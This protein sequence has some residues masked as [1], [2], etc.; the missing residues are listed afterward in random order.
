MHRGKNYHRGPSLYVFTQI[1]CVIFNGNNELGKI[2]RV[3]GITFFFVATSSP[4][5]YFVL[6]KSF[7]G[8][9]SVHSSILYSRN[10]EQDS[11]ECIGHLSL[12][13][14]HVVMSVGQEPHALPP[15]PAALLLPSPQRTLAAS[16]RHSM[17][18]DSPRSSVSPPGLPTTVF[19]ISFL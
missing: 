5:L 1:A 4:S 3:R 17:G 7:E 14:G 15:L 6:E 2:Q 8:P 19:L 10:R 9:T 13:V 16:G 18:D 11:D 12:S